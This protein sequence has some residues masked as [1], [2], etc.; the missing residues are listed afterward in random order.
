M[1]NSPPPAALRLPVELYQGILD[2]VHDRGTLSTLMMTSRA[3]AS[4]AERRLYKSL[5]LVP[6]FTPQTGQLLKQLGVNS[7]VAGYMSSAYIDLRPHPT[8]SQ[9]GELSDQVKAALEMTPNLSELTIFVEA[10]AALWWIPDKPPFKLRILT[11]NTPFDD[12]FISFLN[13]Q[14]H[15]F[16]AKFMTSSRNKIT[17]PTT[18]MPNLRVLSTDMDTA[19]DILP[20][21]N[22]TCLQLTYVNYAP[23]CSTPFRSPPFDSIRR[24]DAPLYPS[25]CQCIGL[26]FPKVEFLQVQFSDVSLIRPALLL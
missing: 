20:G 23:L 9:F 5:Y 3:L 16:R 7:R 1:K 24:L 2:H 12:K 14:T 8:S 11:T 21:R 13:T 25:N 26:F 4:E 6:G 15:L 10:R 18:A 17:I 19:L 22:V